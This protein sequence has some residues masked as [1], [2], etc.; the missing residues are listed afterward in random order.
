MVAASSLSSLP[1]HLPLSAGCSVGREGLGSLTRALRILNLHFCL[2]AMP[3]LFLSLHGF[4]GWDTV[5]FRKYLLSW[6]QLK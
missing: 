2:E 6:K 1:F 5:A 4:N 3:Q